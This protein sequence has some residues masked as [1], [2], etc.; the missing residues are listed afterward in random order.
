MAH[1]GGRP[2]AYKEEYNQ[3]VDEYL[4]EQQDYYDDETKTHKVKLPTVEGFSTFINTSRSNIFKWAKEHE[5]FS[6]SLDKIVKAQ[7]QRLIDNG[8]AGTYNSTIAKLVLSAN[9][10]MREKADVTTDGKEMPTP[11]LHGVLRNDSTS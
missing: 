2:T 11:I 8:L 5:Q 1:A 6:D 4:A 3:K 7:H 9:H 10:G